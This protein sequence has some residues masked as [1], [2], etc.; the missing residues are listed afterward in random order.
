M[1]SVPALN[2]LSRPCTICVSQDALQS[3]GKGLAQ[4]R[5]GILMMGGDGAIE[6]RRIHGWI[7]PCS[8]R[9]LRSHQTNPELR[10]GG[11]NLVVKIV[12]STVQATYA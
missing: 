1:I 8:G 10:S 5:S 2:D 6:W 11:E 12:M 7:V 9:E 3:V 4:Y